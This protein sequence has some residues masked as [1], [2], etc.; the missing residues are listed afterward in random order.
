MKRFF[1]FLLLVCCIRI[2]LASQDGEKGNG[3]INS[4]K[5]AWDASKHV[6]SNTHFKVIGACFWYHSI[7]GIP[8]SFYATLALDEYIPDL[9]VSVYNGNDT[10]PYTEF[11]DTYDKVDQVSGQYL[12][13]AY[14]GFNIY[15]NGQVN[16]SPVQSK[17]IE[18]KVKSVDVVGAPLNSISIPFQKLTSDTTFLEPYYMSSLDAVPD[19]SG[20]GELIY[21]DRSVDFLHYY[22]GSGPKDYWGYEFPRYMEIAQPN[23]Y[24]ASVVLAQRAADI[25][26]NGNSGHVVNSLHDS[27]GKHNCA[28][29]TVIE[30]NQRDHE[31]WEMVYPEDKIIQPGQSDDGDG[32]SQGSDYESQSNGNY[33]FLLWRHYRGC[34]QGDHYL[35]ATVKVN[36]TKKR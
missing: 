12:I 17:D 31:I 5:I 21:S 16:T 29:S 19:R 36:D 22:I 13:S 26:S 28:V 1:I 34:V 23:D 25:A 24:K 4:A 30:E 6:F 15:E 35:G 7:A 8:T 14:T 3:S 33:V 27:C 11:R 18:K 32:S 9:V 10:N 20:L 2:T